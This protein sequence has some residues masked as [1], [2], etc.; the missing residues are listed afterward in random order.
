V[1][2]PLDAAHREHE[3][4]GRAVR[5]AEPVRARRFLDVAAMLASSEPSVNSALQ[6]ARA[7][8]E[9]RPPAGC[10]ER[11]PLPHS[12]RERELVG[13]FADAFES[14]GISALTAFTDTSV[15]ARCGLPGTLRG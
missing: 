1:L 10:R 14:G 2:S 9:A 7:A 4:P 5:L 13:S 11:A 12:P 8:L 3:L 15:F 6:R